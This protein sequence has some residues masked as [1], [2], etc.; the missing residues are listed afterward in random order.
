MNT[1]SKI[2][3]I[4]TDVA[5]SSRVVDAIKHPLWGK[6][7]LDP[8]AFTTMIQMLHGGCKSSHL[9]AM[10]IILSNGKITIPKNIEGNV[11]AMEQTILDYAIKNKLI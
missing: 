2:E 9:I 7:R 4:I 10:I 1:T 8:N 11:V 3:T 6:V 5:H